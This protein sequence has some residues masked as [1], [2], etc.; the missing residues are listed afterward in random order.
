M[1]HI[2]EP[3]ISGNSF[4]HSTHPGFRVGCAFI[5]SLCGALV[6]NINAAGSVFAC[7]VIFAIA[8]RLPFLKLVK[9][10]FFVNFFIFFLWIFL[11][12]SRPGDPLFTIGPFTATTQGVVYTAI[13]TL[14]SNGVILAMTSLISTMAVQQMGAGMQSLRIPD[15]FCRLFLFTWRYVHV[16]STEFYKMRRAA[17][18]RNFQ[19]RT[20]LRT[21]QTYAWLMGMLLVRSLDRAQR[22]W[23]A[24]ICRGFTGTFHTLNSLE[25]HGRDWG[26][27][28]LSI[29]FSTTFIVL[30]FY[31]I[32]V[33]L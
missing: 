2:T 5:F 3:F 10:L 25:V 16:M 29:A 7:G 18:M 17:T 27:L 9:R 11:P 1:Q 8:A 24:M 28:M 23:Q 21:Y 33:L 26:L 19:P 31:K 13:I 14:K 15:K 30:E 22:V 6:T 12:F 32:G 4:I 20:N